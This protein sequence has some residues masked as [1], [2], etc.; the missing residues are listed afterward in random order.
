MVAASKMPMLKP[1]EY[2]LWRMG[3]EQYIQMVDYSLWEV[4]ENGNAPSITKLVKGV[5]TI[6]APSTI[7]EKVQ[8]RLELKARST[9]LMGI[10]NEHQLK[11]NSIK[12]AK[13]LMHAIK[14]RFGGNA[15][16]KKTQRNLLKQ[17]NS[18]T[19]GAVNTAH[20]VTTASTQATA[21]N[22]TTIDN[23]NDVVIY[24]LEVPDGYANNEGKKILEEHCKK[25]YY[26]WAPMNQE[27]RNKENTRRVVPVETTT[28]NAFISCD[29]LGDYDWSD[30]AKEVQ[31]TL[32]SWLTLLQV[33]TL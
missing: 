1:S 15:D 29:G 26:E 5:E 9:L 17:Y 14:K 22:S 16:T 18:S 27:N 12:D 13:S 11:F 4:I 20:G 8:K 25:T 24:G 10:P 2:E 6:I 19:N 3:M 21:V 31:L 28:S 23:L 33:L 32:Y 30:Q 7:E